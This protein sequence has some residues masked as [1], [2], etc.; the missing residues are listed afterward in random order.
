MSP[1]TLNEANTPSLYSEGKLLCKSVSVGRRES[2][3]FPAFHSIPKPRFH[4][5]D[6]DFPLRIYQWSHRFF[7]SLIAKFYI[8]FAHSLAQQYEI[9]LEME[10]FI[11]NSS[12]FQEPPI[13]TFDQRGTCGNHI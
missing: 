10:A 13:P 9:H 12:L 3:D 7:H 1:Y 11:K 4:S 2:N 8:Y 6:C 5:N